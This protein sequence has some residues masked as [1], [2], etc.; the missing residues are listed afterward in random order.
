MRILFSSSSLRRLVFG[1][2]PHTNL[3]RA[4]LMRVVII[5][6]SMGQ[7]LNFKLTNHVD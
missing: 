1:F 6:P 2:L 3:L 7:M 5:V 4:Y